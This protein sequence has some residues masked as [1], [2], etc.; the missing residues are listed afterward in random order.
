MINQVILMI[1]MTGGGD[2]PV[3]ASFIEVQ[4]IAECE[5]RAANAIAVF[6]KAGIN[7]VRH[8]CVTSKIK[9]DDFLHNPEPTGPKY[10]FNLDISPDGK[11]LD[12]AKPYA[13]LKECQQAGGKSCVIA[14]QN[15]KP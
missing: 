3:D 11:N 9:F 8:N 15:I 2:L 14:Y 10:I 4:T 7:Y 1:M 12:A 6:P 13:S 5:Q